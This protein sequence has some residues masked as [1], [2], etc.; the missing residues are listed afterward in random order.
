MK[1][2]KRTSENT[3]INE[4]ENPTLQN[5]WDVAKAV[6]RGSF[7]ATGLPPETRKTS[8]KQPNPS[9]EGVRKRRTKPK[10]SRRK[11]TIKIREEIN[12]IEIKKNRKYQ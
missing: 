10:V 9:P 4:N 12:K 1:K 6:L 8:H 5:L 11:G 3:S 7:I 2:S